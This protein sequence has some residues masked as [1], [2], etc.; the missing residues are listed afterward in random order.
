MNLPGKV[1]IVEVGPRDGL[2]NEKAILDTEI[3]KEYISKLAQAGLKNIEVTSFVSPKAIPQMA[4]AAKLYPEVAASMSGVELPCLVPNIKGYEAALAAG[5]KTI[6]LF[7]A[8]S[9]AFTKKNINATLED[10][11]K[12]MEEVA[13]RAK[14]DGIRLR[15]YISTAYGCPY[16][17]EMKVD[18]L[19]KVL[20]KLFK[21]GAYEVSIGD[22]IGVA[23][24]K[25]V[26]EFFVDMLQH[27]DRDKLAMHF[28]DTRGLALANI[29]VSLQHG[30]TTYDASSG[31]LGGCPYARGATGN[32]AT[33]DVVNLFHSMGIETGI[34]MKKLV[35]ASSYILE[36]LEKDSPSKFYNSFKSSGK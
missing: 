35:D 18:A 6:A 1:Q 11:F 33:E 32:V 9:E 34:D 23:N 5:V 19:K 21:L 17:G 27:F 16:A 30:I 12:R 22:T 25:Q 7:T 20:D 31:G 3:K 4:D 15:G 10:S 28:H 14:T 24:P 26:D 2:Q 36:K 29:M 8:T 13:N